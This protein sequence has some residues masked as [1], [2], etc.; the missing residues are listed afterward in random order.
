MI[1]GSKFCFVEVNLI[2]TIARSNIRIYCYS[3]TIKKTVTK[4]IKCLYHYIFNSTLIRST[5]I[6]C[7]NIGHLAKLRNIV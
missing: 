7:S 5:K 6:L 3:S 4:R 2:T 1:L